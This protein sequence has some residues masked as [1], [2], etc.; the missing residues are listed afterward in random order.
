MFE[1]GLH[2][3]L[4][5]LATLLVSSW[6]ERKRRIWQG[7]GIAIRLTS[8]TV[9]EATNLS[10]T[11][12]FSSCTRQSSHS[13]KAGNPYIIVCAPMVSG[14]NGKVAAIF[15]LSRGETAA[16]RRARG[17][18]LGDRLKRSTSVVVLNESCI[19]DDGTRDHRQVPLA[20]SLTR[21]AF[22]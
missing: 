8:G 19:I 13:H 4:W 20:A 7:N 10:D 16:E 9:I 1:A 14:D 17:L 21:G 11:E 15:H 3:Q 5:R 18:A 6:N 12:G 2:R 22:E